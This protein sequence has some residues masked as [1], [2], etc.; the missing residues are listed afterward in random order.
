VL[1]LVVVADFLSGHAVALGGGVGGLTIVW[2]IISTIVVGLIND[3]IPTIPVIPPVGAVLLFIFFGMSGCG[4]CN[5]GK[6]SSLIGP[7]NKEGHSLK[8]WTQ[9][10]E[11]LS[12]T[13]IRLVPIEHANSIAKT[14]LNQ[15][16]DDQGNIVGSQFEIIDD[17]TTLQKVK[18]EMVYVAPLDYRNWGTYNGTSGVPGYVTINAEDQ[19]VTPQYHKGYRMIYTPEAYW[20]NNL[21]RHLYTNGYSDKI[22]MDYSFEIDDSLRP[23]WVVSVCHASIG[24]SGIV[25]DGVAVVNPENGDITYYSK[26]KAPVWID[27]IIPESVVQNNVNYWGQYSQGFWNT[28]AVG[29]QSN[30]RKAESTLL[31][32]GADGTCWYVTPVT[33]NNGNDHTM[34]DV[35][36]TNSRTGE[37]RRYSVSGVT[38]EKITETVD[39]TVSFQH[40]HAAAIV[41][42][43]V[44][45]R[46]TAIVPILAEDHSIRGLA[47]VDVTTKSMV[48]DT[49]PQQAL[50]KYQNSLSGM[51]A[52]IGTD[53]ASLESEIFSKVTRVS[54][55]TTSTGSIYYLYF[56]G[57]PHI[58]SVPQTYREIVITNPGDSVYIKFLDM[59]SEIIAV[60]DF[61]NRTV[62]VTRSKNEQEVHERLAKRRSGEKTD[63]MRASTKNTIRNG[64]VSDSLLDAVGKTIAQ[65][66]NK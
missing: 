9:Q 16:S 23:F 14:A 57:S 11:E 4:A 12:P 34:T 18:N 17:N 3:E 19:H 22:L 35:I 50:M 55:S 5:P 43:N 59:A 8:H 58:Y 1:F 40:L 64:D 49:D 15:G 13:H 61:E 28:T 54:N 38:E 39:A 65:P 56:E 27:R 29:S 42:E 60:S 37:S 25:V 45:D 48:W 33:S 41:F 44:G 21:E 53:N 7:L 6:Y 51:S 31:N 47:L 36:Y 62:H 66:K 32:Y 10:T 46:M 30:V 52:A 26:D 63:A 20:S 2:L 24:F